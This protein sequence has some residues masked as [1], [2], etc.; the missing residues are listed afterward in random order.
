[1]SAGL[2]DGF[3]R[4]SD[5]MR[6]VAA[7]ALFAQSADAPTLISAHKRIRNI[8]KQNA[9]TL[10]G[11]GAPVFH[12]PAEKRLAAELEACQAVVREHANK[13]DYEHV[14][15]LLGGLRPAIDGFFQE[16]LVMTDDPE[17]RRSRLTLLSQLAALFELIGDLSCLRVT[18]EPT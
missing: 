5:A 1:V 3:T 2:K 4:A 11:H 9:A 8:L 16:V 18:G 10:E 14:L 17:A 6:R 13:G 7:L 15:T 12:E